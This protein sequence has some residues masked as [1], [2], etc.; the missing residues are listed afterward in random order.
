MGGATVEKPGDDKEAHQEEFKKLHIREGKEKKPLEEV[1][2][3]HLEN[4]AR[5]VPSTAERRFKA[6]EYCGARRL[7]IELEFEPATKHEGYVKKYLE[8]VDSIAG[9]LRAEGITGYYI[10]NGKDIYAGFTDKEKIKLQ[11][12]FIKGIWKAAQG[13]GIKF[14]P[15]SG[16]LHESLN[17]G[18]WNG[19][20]G[21]ALLFDVAKEL[22]I[23]A[24]IVVVPG[25]VFVKTDDFFFE[26]NSKDAEYRPLKKLS[27]MYPFYTASS[28]LEVSDAVAYNVRGIGYH[29]KGELDKALWDYTKAI[30][31]NPDY[32]DAYFNRGHLYHNKKDYDKE[33][34]N[35]TKVIKLNPNCFEAYLFRGIA[36]SEKRQ[37]KQALHDFSRV[38]ELNLMDRN[39]MADVHI[40]RGHNYY[41]EDDYDKAIADLNKA[42]ELN[43]TLEEKYRKEIAAITRDK[44]N[45]AGRALKSLDDT[46]EF[47]R[48][49]SCLSRGEYDEA[50]EHFSR[51]IKQDPKDALAY[52]GRGAS[53]VLKEE[54]DEAIPDLEESLSIDPNSDMA[55]RY[56]DVARKRKW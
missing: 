53:H 15:K 33:V 21:S 13:R 50:I 29:E 17:R 16:L 45:N 46:D 22:G 40:L 42:I 3:P 25:H 55:R 37:Y 4:K 43:P 52:M 5:E 19:N 27:K 20:R 47:D 18:L 36:Y 6:E 56:L 32:A 48:G 41:Y 39:D 26:T 30:E 49:I 31:L 35:L 23:P 54:Y 24:E 14:E 38:I 51:A 28:K 7:R 9:I 1:N 10:K 34:E 2:P 12:K 8:L 44:E 11:E